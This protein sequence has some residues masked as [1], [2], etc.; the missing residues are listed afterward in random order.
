MNY[1]EPRKRNSDSCWDW[2]V[3][4]NKKIRAAGACIDCECSHATA[5]EAREHESERIRTLIKEGKRI[6]IDTKF[7]HDCQC[8]GC[9]EKAFYEIRIPGK[10]MMI[11][12]C[13]KHLDNPSWFVAHD[14]MSS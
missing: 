4:R 2:S 7:G 14:E 1:Y 10:I 12:A 6:E 11:T 9:E 13:D 5:E 8:D 3:M